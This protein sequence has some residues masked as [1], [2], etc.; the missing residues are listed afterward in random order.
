MKHTFFMPLWFV[1]ISCIAILLAWAYAFLYFLESRV[2]IFEQKIISIFTS[3]SDVFPAL[4]E[5]GRWIILR[6]NEIFNEAMELRKKEFIMIW[7]STNLEA[8]LELEGKL[9]HE[10]NFIFQICN[11]NPVLLTDKHFLYVR[12]IIM[13]KSQNI[14]K[15]MK[16][17]RK[18]IE[19]YNKIISIK[20]YT[21]IWYI[22]PFH[23]KTIL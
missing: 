10:I 19:I 2:F 15:N 22:L 21:I 18:I 14:S 8:F 1:I 12:D 9:H 23:K 5:V 7:V 17:Y 20:N 16:K 11:K 13:E 4:Y 6:Q 3:R